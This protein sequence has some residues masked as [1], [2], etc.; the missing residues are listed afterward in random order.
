M[1]RRILGPSF[2]NFQNEHNAVENKFE[3]WSTSNIRQSPLY[4]NPIKRYQLCKL[5][6]FGNE[7]LNFFKFCQPTGPSLGNALVC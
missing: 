5:L 7:A 3:Y 6:R 4:S 2:C 1:P